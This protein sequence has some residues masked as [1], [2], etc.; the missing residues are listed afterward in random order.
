MWHP[1]KPGVCVIA[2]VVAMPITVTAGVIMMALVFVV[3]P[4][5]L[6]MVA[7]VMFIVMPVTCLHGKT[8]HQG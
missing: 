8:D 7:T 3:M 6:I 2:V 5:V 4:L 1:I